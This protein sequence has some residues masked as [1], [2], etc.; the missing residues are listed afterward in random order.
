MPNR[1]NRN[2]EMITLPHRTPH[3][4]GQIKW[5]FPLA[6]PG[7]WEEGIRSVFGRVLPPHGRTGPT[8]ANIG[9]LGWG[10]GVINAIEAMF[11]HAVKVRCW[12]HRLSNI[13]AKLADATAP[14]VM[15]EIRSIRDA[16]TSLYCARNSESFRQQPQKRRR[17]HQP[18]YRRPHE[19]TPSLY[20]RIRT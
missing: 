12:F 8:N 10:G 16:R 13:R 6:A 20:R 15:A 9:H 3:R 18:K 1:Q 17:T 14:E 7:C 11:P 19:L 2:H 5:T 4:W